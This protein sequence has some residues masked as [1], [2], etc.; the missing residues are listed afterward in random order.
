[1]ITEDDSSQDAVYL[2]TLNPN[3]DNF[4]YAFEGVQWGA[5]LPAWLEEFVDPKRHE[6]GRCV[7]QGVVS[8]WVRSS[9]YKKN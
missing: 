7:Y 3:G 4:P 9:D 8:F 6:V 5:E 1:M 2:H